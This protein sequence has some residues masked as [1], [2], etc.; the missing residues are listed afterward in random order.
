MIMRGRKKILT[1]EQILQIKKLALEGYTVKSLSEIFNISKGVI[2][3]IKYAKESYKY[4]CE[5]SNIK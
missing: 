5:T 3:N 4:L 2:I 1:D